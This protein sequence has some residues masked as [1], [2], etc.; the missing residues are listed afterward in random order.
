MITVWKY[1]REWGISTGSD[2]RN[3]REENVG[4]SL[5]GRFWFLRLLGNDRSEMLE[6][7]SRGLVSSLQNEELGEC[8]AGKKLS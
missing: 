6:S 8:W 2:E 5:G 4:W 1:L 7:P 3:R